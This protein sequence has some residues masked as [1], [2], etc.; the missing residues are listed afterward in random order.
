MKPAAD[1]YQDFLAL[2]GTST[3]EENRQSLSSSKKAKEGKEKPKKPTVC[4]I[5][6]CI[7][8]L[9]PRCVYSSRKLTNVEQAE[10][11]RY[12][13]DYLYS[14]GGMIIPKSSRIVGLSC[15]EFLDGCSEV[16]SPHYFATRLTNTPCCYHYGAVGDLNPI[17]KERS[18]AI[19]Q[20][21]Q[22]AT[23]ATALE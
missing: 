18:R 20:C 8:C 4:S 2:W 22:F 19:K 10:L 21:I 11:Q 16:I 7:E 23:T 9:K 14:C 13:E 12:K 6:Y 15:T 17:T 3:S 5:V 1:S